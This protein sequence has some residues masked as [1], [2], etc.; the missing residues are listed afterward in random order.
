[1]TD[2]VECYLV[3]TGP[4]A[5]IARLKERVARPYESFFVGGSGRQE[6]HEE[7]GDFLLWNCARPAPDTLPDY[8]SGKAVGRDESTPYWYRWNVSNW[9]TKWE[10]GGDFADSLDSAEPGCL[11]YRFDTAYTPPLEAVRRL[12]RDYPSV[13]FILEAEEFPDGTSGIYAFRAG[14][15]SLESNWMPEGWRVTDVGKGD[16]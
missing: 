1:M 16:V 15:M 9:G 4:D 6:R 2:W 11:T 13:E 8:W 10:V 3:I 7:V 12:S 5:D 14:K